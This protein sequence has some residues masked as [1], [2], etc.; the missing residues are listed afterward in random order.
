MK[1]LK[2]MSALLRSALPFWPPESQI[3]VKSQH[4]QTGKVLGLLRD[5]RIISRVTGLGYNTVAG[6][7]SGSR[8]AWEG[9]NAKLVGDSFPIQ[10]TVP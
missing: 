8:R 4:T 10:S 7:R 5:Q 1:A 3:E 9:Q 2:T 6:P